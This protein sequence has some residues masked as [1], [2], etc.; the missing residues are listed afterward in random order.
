VSTSVTE[1]VS[2][3]SSSAASGPGHCPQFDVCVTPIVHTIHTVDN[4]WWQRGG[5]AVVFAFGALFLAILVAWLVWLWFQWRD[6]RASRRDNEVDRKLERQ[7]KL[8]MEE[9]R[10][11]Q[12]D[13]VKTDPEALRMLE[14]RWSR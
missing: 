1:I 13:M 10:T 12:M 14:K 8:D 3:G 9:Q 2:G 6:S 4:P 11:M 7:H 5:G